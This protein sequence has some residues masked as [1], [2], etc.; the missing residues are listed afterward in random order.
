LESVIVTN[1]KHGVPFI[2]LNGSQDN[3]KRTLSLFH[4]LYHASLMK[5]KLENDSKIMLNRYVVFDLKKHLVI[6]RNQVIPLPSVEY[7]LLKALCEKSP[8]YL[9]TQQLLDIVWG[10]NKFVNVDTVYVHIRRLRQK[11]EITPDNPRILINRKGVGYR[12]KSDFD[13]INQEES[14]WAEQISQNKFSQGEI[15]VGSGNTFTG[16]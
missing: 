5:A 1:Q 13:H 11:I 3:V 8:G 2:L 16:R 6:N 15:E 10:E 12:I 14:H 9:S 7:K 4:D